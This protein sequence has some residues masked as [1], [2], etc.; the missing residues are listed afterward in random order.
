M[1]APTLNFF[2]DL[3]AVYTVAFEARPSPKQARSPED[4]PSGRVCATRWGGRMTNHKWVP[5]SARM[6]HD[7][8]LVVLR[9]MESIR[10][11]VHHAIG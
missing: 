7:G 11:D 5:V 4:K 8:Q 1:R 9:M 10:K 3:S 6:P 2:H